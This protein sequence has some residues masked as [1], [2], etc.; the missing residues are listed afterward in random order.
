MSWISPENSSLV[1]LDKN[2]LN[3]IQS[4]TADFFKVVQPRK[5]FSC[6]CRQNF[7]ASFKLRK[8]AILQLDIE[9]V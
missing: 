9:N 5:Q 1:C 3:F 2:L 4:D 8:K 6:L 7:P